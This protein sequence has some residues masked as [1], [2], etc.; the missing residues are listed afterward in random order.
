MSETRGRSLFY[1]VVAGHTVR[2]TIDSDTN[3]SPTD[4]DLMVVRDRF[5]EALRSGINS[6]GPYAGFEK[7]ITVKAQIP[8]GESAAFRAAL[9]NELV[10]V[11]TP[12]KPDHG[13]VSP[14]TGLLGAREQFDELHG[15]VLETDEA[16]E[17]RVMVHRLFDIIDNLTNPGDSA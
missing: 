3:E 8:P 15:E 1:I 6:G 10:D 16:A 5:P 4:S 9:A 7:N 14:T 11:L 13:P 2:I 12:R 17:L